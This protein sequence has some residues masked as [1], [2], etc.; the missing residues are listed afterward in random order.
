MHI[1]SGEK[2]LFEKATPSMIPTIRWSG[3]GKTMEIV[4][5]ISDC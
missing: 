1:K 5:Q 2:K 3:K 4:K